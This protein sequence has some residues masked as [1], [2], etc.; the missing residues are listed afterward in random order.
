MEWRSSCMSWRWVAIH[1]NS[2]CVIVGVFLP[3]RETV[4]RTS[5]NHPRLTRYGI[6]LTVSEGLSECSTKI[7]LGSLSIIGESLTFELLHKL[8][9]SVV[10]Q[11]DE[12]SEGWGAGKLTSSLPKKFPLI[13][14]CVKNVVRVLQRVEIQRR[15][16]KYPSV[17]SK[18]Y[19]SKYWLTKLT[20]L[21]WKLSN[22]VTKTS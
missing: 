21:P 4:I 22:L 19:K 1:S 10:N 9:T 11:W 16:L 13:A 2:S 5:I 18:F 8:K 3:M 17:E 6:T 14:N 12:G 20:C 7:Y 15:A